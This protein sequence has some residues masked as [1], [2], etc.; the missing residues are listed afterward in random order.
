MDE[1]RAARPEDG[2]A[3]LG[4]A[5]CRYRSDEVC[6]EDLPMIA[7][8][9]L[10]AGADTP[11]LCEL[12]GW[13]RTADPR[14]I[15]D[16]FERALDEAGV[17]LP[18]PDVAR[19]HALRRTAARLVAGEL[20]PGGL[21][22]DAWWEAQGETEAERALLALIPACECCAAYTLGLDQRTWERRLREAAHART[23]EPP[24]AP[25]C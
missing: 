11:S 18:D 15:R 19:R 25:G 8:E 14:D 10:A 21:A 16:A 5:A 3:M 13:P 20:A 2:A 6:P 7:A 23:A 1:R 12:A 4:E 17:S 22:T 9:A 24:V